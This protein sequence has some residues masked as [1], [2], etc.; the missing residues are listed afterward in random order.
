VA[1]IARSSRCSRSSR[2]TLIRLA[3]TSA[4]AAL[5]QAPHCIS[6]RANASSVRQRRIRWAGAGDAV[7]Q[8]RTRVVD[9]VRRGP[10]HPQT[11]RRAHLLVHRGPDER[12]REAHVPRFS[13]G[14]TAQQARG[15]GFLQRSERLGELCQRSGGPQ[16]GRR[17]PR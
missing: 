3:S 8:R 10:V 7:A 12:M 2:S 13:R 14:G 16:R 17:L 15:G 6:A 11:R 9:Q 5:A 4:F 1:S